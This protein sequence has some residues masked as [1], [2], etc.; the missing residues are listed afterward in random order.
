MFEPIHGSAPKYAGKG[1]ASPLGSIGALALML[2]YLG[3]S[4]ASRAIEDAIRDGL[5][6]GRIKGVEAGSQRTAEV[7][8]IVALTV[9]G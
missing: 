9:A 8:D 3:E 1:M 2:E 6:S 7:A 5:R 4:D